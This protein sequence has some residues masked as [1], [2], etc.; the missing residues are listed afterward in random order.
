MDKDTNDW[1]TAMMKPGMDAFEYWVSFWPVAPMFGVEWR[2]GNA[3]MGFGMVPAKATKTAKTAKGAE[4]GTAKSPAKPTAK[5]APAANATPAKVSPMPAP[6]PKKPSAKVPSAEET[7]RMS[8]VVEMPAPKAAK[9]K[10]DPKAKSEAKPKAGTKTKPKAPKTEPA[11]PAADGTPVGLMASAPAKPDDLKLIKGVGPSLEKQLNALGVY[12][13]DQLA[14]FASPDLQW[15][16]DNLT[17]FKGR[18]FRD[19]WIGQAKVL[20]AG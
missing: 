9:L 6:K 10:A 19:D 12:T 11:A 20:M 7:A 5:V 3:D 15:I 13:F 16:D 2:F 8:N 4:T 14:G 1:V 17:S 18:C